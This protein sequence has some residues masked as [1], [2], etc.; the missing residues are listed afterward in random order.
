MVRAMQLES[1]LTEKGL[2][3]IKLNMNQQSVLVARVAN[4]LYLIQECQWAEGVILPLH[5]ALVR[6]HL[7]PCVEFWVHSTRRHECTIESPLK[8][9]KDN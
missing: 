8:G 7:A 9:H 1:T 2:V 3:D 4:G 5:L 6:L